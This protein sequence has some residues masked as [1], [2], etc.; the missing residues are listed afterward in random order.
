MIV[1]IFKQER[2]D[3]ADELCQKQ[4][5]ITMNYLGPYTSDVLL[6]LE[7]GGRS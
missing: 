3:T 4:T 5:G 2:E 1:D 7:V 6:T